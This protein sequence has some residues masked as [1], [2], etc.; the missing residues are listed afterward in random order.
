MDLSQFD[1]KF[2]IFGFPVRVMVSFWLICVFF[3]PFLRGQNGPWLF[4]LLG[5]SAAVFLSIL[6]HELGHAFAMRKVYGSTPTIDLGIGSTASGAF[7]FGGLTSSSTSDRVPIKRA[8]TAAAGPIVE[9]TAAFALALLLIPLGFRFERT[10]IFGVIPSISADVESFRFFGSLPLIYFTYFFVEGFVF[11]G[12]VWGLFNLAPIFPCD[13]GQI[14]LSILGQ[15]LGADGVRITMIVSIAL[16]AALGYLFLREESYF[17]AFF[18]FFSAYQNY[19][20]LSGWR[21]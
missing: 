1:W 2:K 20:V 21:R 8:L 4:G 14:L 19:R 6:V 13:G 11:V 10:T 16:S 5:W 7:V 9:I 3:S 15:S 17:M 18:F 12:I